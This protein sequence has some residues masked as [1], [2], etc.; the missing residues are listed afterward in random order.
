MRGTQFLKDLVQMASRHIEEC[1]TSLAIR[2]IKT[3]LRLHFTTVR[4]TIFFYGINLKII[5]SFKNYLFTFQ[6]LPPA[7]SSP[8]PQFQ[9]PL[10][11]PLA[12]KRVIFK[13]Q[14]RHSGECLQSLH[15]GGRG[16][17]VSEASVH[18]LSSQPVRV[19]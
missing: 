19:A 12:S 18:I 16:R 17:Q 4:I 6:L 8:L 11:L 9:V 3:T 14:V 1:L 15:Q 5:F 10:L 7:S 2:E 13:K